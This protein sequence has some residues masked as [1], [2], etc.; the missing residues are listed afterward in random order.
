MYPTIAF[1]ASPTHSFGKGS[2]IQLL[3]QFS[4]LHADKKQIS[5]GLIGYP[6]VGKSSVIN[7]LKASKV[8]KVAPV[9]GETKV[10]QYIT[11]TKRI[12]LI[13]CPGIVPSSANDSKTATVLKGVVR[14]E[15]LP[16]PSEHV[17]ALLERVKPIYISRTYSIPL[18]T[19]SKSSEPG[20]SPWTAE[21]LLEK[22]ARMKGRLL[23]GGEPDIEGVAK[24]ILNDWVRGKLPFFVPPPERPESEMGIVESTKQD[25]KE[26]VKEL[27]PALQ[28]LG[29]I[30]QKNKFE[31]ED[32]RPLEE[33][34]VVGPGTANDDEADG[35]EDPDSDSYSQSSSSE[36][37]SNNEN[38]RSDEELGWDDVMGAVMRHTSKGEDTTLPPRNMVN[39]QKD[40]DLTS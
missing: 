29:G 8:C 31:G 30:I 37:Q 4:R 3:R 2:L 25:S 26:K 36:D 22:L 17:D 20:K 16:Q 14:V 9:P 38:V 23:K 1:H 19:S 7:T 6:N 32:M 11:L 13:D 34:Q 40:L 35:N 27:K 5:V 39:S 12:Y 10:W 21:E 33:E 18:P 24:M 15:A 28:K